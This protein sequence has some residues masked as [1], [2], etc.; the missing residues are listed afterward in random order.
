MHEQLNKFEGSDEHWETLAMH[1][2]EDLV[3]Q[4]EIDTSCYCV[5]VLLYQLT[6]SYRQ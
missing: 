4:P 6:G 3:V 5:G 1:E 2:H